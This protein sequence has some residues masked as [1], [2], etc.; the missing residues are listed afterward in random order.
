MDTTPDWN[1]VQ[2]RLEQL[3]PHGLDA[4]TWEQLQRHSLTFA[5]DELLWRVEA[6]VRQVPAHGTIFLRSIAR[7]DQQSGS[8]AL[9]AEQSGGGLGQR[10][11]L[12]V[13]AISLVVDALKSEHFLTSNVSFCP[14]ERA[15]QL[16]LLSNTALE[17]HS[18]IRQL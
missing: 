12:C 16:L 14:E 18:H 1:E 2:E 8:C 7:S 3:L 11:M 15:A 6:I 4:A 9:C 13:T 17:A 10:C 5:T